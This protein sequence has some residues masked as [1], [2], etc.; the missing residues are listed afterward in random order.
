[1]GKPL[2]SNKPKISGYPYSICWRYIQVRRL[3]K[4]TR[5]GY[6]FYVIRGERIFPSEIKL[7]QN[8]LTTAVKG[9]GKNSTKITDLFEQIQLTK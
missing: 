9:I 5:K 4:E 8:F 7:I 6:W 3:L 2:L 1:M